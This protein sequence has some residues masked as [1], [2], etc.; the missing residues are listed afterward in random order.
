MLYEII[1]ANGDFFGTNLRREQTA[2]QE[3]V[4]GAEEPS[5]SMSVQVEVLDGKDAKKAAVMTQAQAEMAL[6]REAKLLQSAGAIP[7][8]DLGK[9]GDYSAVESIAFWRASDPTVSNSEFCF[10]QGLISNPKTG[11]R[12][13]LV[14]D[15]DIGKV[16]YMSIEYFLDAQDWDTNMVH[17]EREEKELRKTADAFAAYH[18]LAIDKALQPVYDADLMN[19]LYVMTNADYEIMTE[20]QMV[21]VYQSYKMILK[22]ADLL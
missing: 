7:H 14:I 10:W 6:V 17:M 9:Q 11:E 3:K 13:H 16:Y 5:M 19:H 22:P 1:E 20:A 18:E 8:F 2:E 4:S 12:Y 21:P 15:D